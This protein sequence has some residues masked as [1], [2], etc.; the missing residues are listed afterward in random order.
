MT[1]TRRLTQRGTK[2]FSGAGHPKVRYITVGSP[3]VFAVLPAV[4]L[5]MI[6]LRVFQNMP[7]KPAV[8]SVCGTAKCEA[9]AGLPIFSQP[10]G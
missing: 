3:Y 7:L 8:R 5:W 4:G 6:C 10:T 1:C 2:A 9:T